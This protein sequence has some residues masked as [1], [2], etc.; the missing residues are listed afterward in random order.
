VSV[1]S[2]QDNLPSAALV[3]YFSFIFFPSSHFPTQPG[4]W[5]LLTGK[6]RYSPSK[7]ILLLVLIDGNLEL[8]HECQKA[9]LP[10]TYYYPGT[11]SRSCMTTSNYS[12]T[13]TPG[14]FQQQFQLLILR[15]VTP[16]P[17]SQHQLTPQEARSL[18]SF[19]A[20]WGIT[21]LL[22]FLLCSIIQRPGPRVE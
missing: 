22:V 4:Q 7:T 10:H 1:A 17:R 20:C 9:R 3:L 15:S 21:W 5:T 13:S 19:F 6:L 2:C 8:V 11:A 12:T 14:F 18:D 16:T